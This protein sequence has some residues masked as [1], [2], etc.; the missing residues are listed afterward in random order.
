MFDKGKKKVSSIEKV[1][2]L[3]KVSTHA[4]AEAQQEEH[5]GDD[6]DN[7]G[8]VIDTVDATNEVVEEDT[9]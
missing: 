3:F 6:F 8:P 4:H 2:I 9:F 1:L 7:D 5:W